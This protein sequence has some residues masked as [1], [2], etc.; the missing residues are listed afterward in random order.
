M[1]DYQYPDSASSPSTGDKGESL[2][3]KLL[4]PS[5]WIRLLLIFLMYV[6]LFTV[7]QFIVTICMLVQWVLV[8]FNGETNSRLR[9]FTRGLNR[10]AYQIMQYLNF[11]SD[12]CPFPLADWPESGE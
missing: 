10:Y 6:I 9:H 2:K 5:H 7:V 12:E 4:N 11:N 3:Q 1:S 8:L